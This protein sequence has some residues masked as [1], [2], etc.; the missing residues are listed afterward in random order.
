[1]KFRWNGKLYDQAAKLKLGDITVVERAT[2]L[3]SDDWSRTLAAMAAVF[4]SVRRVDPD[5]ITW[6]QLEDLDADALDDLI[7]E[8]EPK[9][10]AAEV[11]GDPLGDGSPGT[12]GSPG[13]PR[14]RRA[15][16][17]RTKSGAGSTS[18]SSRTTSAGRRPR[19]TT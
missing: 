3:D 10:K 16:A 8:E 18:G 1:V 13:G 7:V 4:A 15:A 6:E 9:P 5:A 14:G 19:S 12:S 17:G 2:G 11:K